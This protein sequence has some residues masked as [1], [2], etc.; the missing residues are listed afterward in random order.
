MVPGGG[1]SD[2][3]IFSQFCIILSICFKLSD[4]MM[5]F[6]TRNPCRSKYHFSSSVKVDLVTSATSFLSKIK[7]HVSPCR[8]RSFEIDQNMIT[9]VLHWILDVGIKRPHIERQKESCFVSAYS[10]FLP[11][12][13][14]TSLENNVLNFIHFFLCYGAGLVV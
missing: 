9:S 5:P 2:S 14:R 1:R 7:R 3:S 10:H 11:K 8:F 13:W 4:V 6:K 12:V